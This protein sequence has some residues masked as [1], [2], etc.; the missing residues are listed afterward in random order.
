MEG[1]AFR[2]VLFLLVG[3]LLT[4]VLIM[5]PFLNP[6]ARE[7]QSEPPGNVIVSI[8]W[9]KDLPHDVDLWVM[10]PGE[11]KPVGYSNKGGLVWNLLRDDLGQDPYSDANFETSYSRGIRAGRYT[12]NVHCYRCP[13]L[14]VPVQVEVSVQATDAQRS[15]RRLLQTT[16]EMKFNGQEATAFSF[17]L[18]ED[19][20]VVPGTANTIF[21]PLREANP[22]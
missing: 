17:F 8:V 15:I 2:D 20:F 3:G 18:T 1:T 22:K 11:V 7:D 12:V 14:P 5:L 9:P 4:I 19:G 13:T 10:G 6:P 16:L 21:R